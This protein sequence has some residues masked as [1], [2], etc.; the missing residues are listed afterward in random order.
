MQ[1]INRTKPLLYSHLAAI[2]RRRQCYKDTNSFWIVVKK[3][4]YFGVFFVI[5]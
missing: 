3:I 4:Q 5:G 1:Y 2:V